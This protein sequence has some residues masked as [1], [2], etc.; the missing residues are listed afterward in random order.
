[1]NSLITSILNWLVV[2]FIIPFI[3]T[4]KDKASIAKK[5]D[6]DKKKVEDLE[7]AKSASD[8]DRAIDNLP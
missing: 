5:V 6:D 1:V 4:I 7:N 3:K 2:N 8:I